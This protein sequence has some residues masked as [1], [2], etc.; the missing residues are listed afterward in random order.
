MRRLFGRHT[1]PDFY[2]LK[3]GEGERG[4]EPRW[5]GGGEKSEETSSLTVT[6]TLLTN[7][8]PRR[9]SRREGL[10]LR[11][12]RKVSDRAG[13]TTTSRTVEGRQ[14]RQRKGRGGKPPV[15]TRKTYVSSPKG[16]DNIPLTDVTLRIRYYLDNSPPPHFWR[17]IWVNHNK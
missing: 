16:P 7:D 13:Q 14:G 5:R 17:T 8:R 2:D 12:E 9:D 15:R 3:S 6:Y 4:R 1:R 11:S 10:G